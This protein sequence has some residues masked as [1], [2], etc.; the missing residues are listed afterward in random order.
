LASSLAGKTILEN[1]SHVLLTSPVGSDNG[2]SF[3][4]GLLLS[5]RICR[6]EFVR[7]EWLGAIFP[8]AGSGPILTAISAA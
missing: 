6:S 3:N 1:L 4:S 8:F 7:N 2:L 5:R